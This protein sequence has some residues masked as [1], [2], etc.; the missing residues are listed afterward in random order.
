M[1]AQSL[2]DETPIQDWQRLL[3]QYDL[4]YHFGCSGSD[5][6]PFINA[7]IRIAPWI[8]ESVLDLGCG[9]GGPARWLNQQ[10]R[11]VTAI[12]HSQAQLNWIQQTPGINTL[13]MDLNDPKDLPRAHTALM[14][15]SFSHIRERQE[16]LVHLRDRCDRL[17]MISHQSLGDS[18]YHP[19]WHMQFD[20]QQAIQAL[21]QSA[22]W[23][24]THWRNAMPE[25]ARLTAECWQRAL[26]R[27]SGTRSHHMELLA[28]LAREILDH[29]GQ[30]L[31]QFG[32]IDLVAE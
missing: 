29:E 7:L 21:L 2:Y 26:A 5:P 22:G 30:F 1:N 32:L 15:E 9:F 23:Q 31:S 25:K 28:Q 10:G 11:Q 17:V 16:L 3:G 4:H 8:G 18:F 24:V 13:W 27:L 6:N 12:S 14:V 19:L 20:N